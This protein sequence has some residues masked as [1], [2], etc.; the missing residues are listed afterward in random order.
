MHVSRTV[1]GLTGAAAMAL[2]AVSAGQ[3]GVAATRGR[4]PTLPGGY[5]HLV[6]I[7]EENHSFDNLYGGWGVGQRPARRTAS[8]TRRAAQQHPGRPGRHAVR[9]PAAG[10]R[11]P[12]LAAADGRPATTPPTASRPATSATGRSSIDDYI[13]P[14]DTTCPAPGVVRP[15]RRPQGLT[16]RQPGGCT[17]DLV[18][19]FYQEQYQLDGGKQDRYITGSDAV[20]LTQG[21]YDT[22]Q[23]PIYRYLHSQARTALRDRRPLLPGRLR[24]V[25]PQPPVPDRRPGPARHQPAA[26]LSADGDEQRARRA[27]ACRPATR[28]TRRPAAWS[29]GS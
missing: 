27:T 8:P 15:Q 28:C 18:H 1:I 22:K 5:K 4:A 26:T 11:Q 7:Y 13:K 3:P 25:V 14:E 16:G 19:R 9:L 2:V 17:R 29:T 24:R 6:V 10:R 23:L 12:H 20:G 21:T